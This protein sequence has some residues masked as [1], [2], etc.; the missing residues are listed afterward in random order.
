MR[1]LAPAFVTL[2]FVA[3]CA[4]RLAVPPSPVAAPSADAGAEAALLARG[5]VDRARLRCNAE[6]RWGATIKP[7]SQAGARDILELVGPRLAPMGDE[8]RGEL[9]KKLASLVMWRMVRAVLLEGD[10]N[11]FGV[12]ALRGRSWTD[13]AGKERPVLVFRSGFTP[14]PD[15]EGS[16][17]GS[18]LDA[19]GVR[20]VVNLFDGEIPAADLVAAESR[21]AARKNASYHTATDDVAGG[22]Y[23]P[24]R[25]QLRKHYDDPAARSEAMRAVARLVREQI[26]HPDGAPSPRGNIHLHCGGGMHR[27][28]MVAAVVE[29]CVNGEPLSVVEDHYRRHVA[30]RDAQHPGGAEEGNL[31]FIRDF[32]CNLLQESAESVTN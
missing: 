31:R 13:A 22:G 21:A 17:F 16:C 20:H 28:G 18:L 8:A 7:D 11:N 32:D 6:N 25:D 29:R 4:A 1:R 12:F 9:A 15:A 2:F 14:D 23:G 3:G 24:W 5:G 19:G 30:W 27:T 10:N 26:L